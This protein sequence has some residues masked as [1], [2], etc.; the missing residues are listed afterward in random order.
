MNH[1]VMLFSKWSLGVV[2]V[3]F[4]V[5]AQAADP[6]IPG[7]V[8]EWKL[9]EANVVSTGQK[10][11]M[12]EGTL[13]R[14]HVIELKAASESHDVVANGKLRLELSLFTPKSSQHGQ[15]KGFWYVRGKWQL[16]DDTSKDAIEGS[17]VHPGVIEGSVQAELASSPAEGKAWGAQLRLPVSTVVAVDAAVSPE[18]K[19]HKARGEGML[20]LD[21]K[22]GGE[23]SL[24]FAMWRRI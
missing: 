11:T 20:R 12:R 17:R 7:S 14:G 21:G 18:K 10:V 19:N 8:Q 23:M 13:I 22:S 4:A 16:I 2:A 6:E 3:L 1:M 9:S 15:K 24:R 5:L